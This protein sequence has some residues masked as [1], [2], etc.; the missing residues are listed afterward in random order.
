MAALPLHPRRVLVAGGDPDALARRLQAARPDLELRA[1]A[2]TA[3][4]AGDLAWADTYV[5]F[6]RPTQPSMGNV[7]WVHSTGAGTDPWFHPT[8]LARDVVL[9]RTSESF[10]PA[11]AEWALA[12]ALAWRQQLSDLADCQRR[13]EWAPREVTYVRGSRAVVLG[14]GDVGTAIGRAFSALGVEVLGVSRSGHGDPAVFATTST[15]DVL[16]AL[17]ATADWLVVGAPLTAETRGLVSRDVLLACRGA[18]LM[19]AGRGA[20][21]DEAAIPEALDR[22]ALAAAILDVFAVEPL[23]PESPLWDHPR[24]MISP[25]MSGRTTVE[26]ALAGFLECLEAFERGERPRWVVDRERGY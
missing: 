26:G 13:R 8:P 18:V 15:P 16:H 23:P 14:T 19:N 10:G 1:V 3:V 17:A 24:V 4:T 11:I 9:T 21:V 5:G 12:R 7:R 6:K 25:H 20:V 22:G 2:T